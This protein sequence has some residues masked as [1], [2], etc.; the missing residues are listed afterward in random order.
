MALAKVALLG[1]G[2]VQI[3]AIRLLGKIGRPAALVAGKLLPLFANDKEQLREVVQL[4]MRQIGHLTIVDARK[5]LA[6]PKA[7]IRLE[8]LRFLAQ[9]DQ[10]IS[11][12]WPDLMALLSGSEKDM[13]AAIEVALARIDQPP[14]E[15]LPL[16]EKAAQSPYPYIQ[17]PA[18]KALEKY[19]NK[20]ASQVSYLI[21]LLLDRH[22]EIRQQT[23]RTLAA[24]GDQAVAPLLQLLRTTPN[25]PLARQAARALGKMNPITILPQL[26]QELVS[27]QFTNDYYQ[28][29]AFAL[30][31]IGP[32]A[33]P[34]L[35]T[36]L[37]DNKR[38]R[39]RAAWAMVY[40]GQLA[41]KELTDLL[42]HP[43][44]GVRRYSAWCLGS[45]A[46]LPAPEGRRPIQRSDG[47]MIAAFSQLILCLRDPKPDVRLE[48]AKAIGSVAP[49]LDDPWKPISELIKLLAPKMADGR[50]QPQALRIEAGPRP[51]SNPCLQS[52]PFL[53]EKNRNGAERYRI[54]ATAGNS[55][56]LTC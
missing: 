28:R 13:R 48:A 14:G 16:A 17:L 39:Q 37:I 4:T 5:A 45:I 34:R 2:E 50:P 41:V 15:N 43:K 18:L 49:H 8:T 32:P 20:A 36:I 29:I 26:S 47:V 19:G 40:M 38:H 23:V 27:E 9:I 1:S 12:L 46:S 56:P 3:R 31:M 52:T 22:Q 54:M 30:G 21:G 35:R 7:A 33:L 25:E 55:P 10:D 53:G 24:I 44:W 6:Y 51:I 11:S 42:S